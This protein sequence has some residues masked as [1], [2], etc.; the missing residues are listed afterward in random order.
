METE[1][2]PGIMTARR[3]I[4][5]RVWPLLFYQ[6]AC[7]F[8]VGAEYIN[9]IT[10]S[11]MIWPDEPANLVA[12]GGLITGRLW[13]DGI[14]A[15]IWGWLIDR[16]QRKKIITFGSIC[17][18]IFITI[19]V[20][21]PIGGGTPD[22]WFWLI[23]RICIGFFMSQGG[24]AIYSLA[25]DF[26]EK[27]EKSRFFGILM[28]TFMIFQ[29][30]GML[31]GAY[32]F[33]TGA[34]QVFLLISA[35]SYF[36]TAIMATKFI[37]EPKRGI[38]EPALSSILS[39]SEARYE[40]TLNRQTLKSTTFS[41]SNIL[42]LAEGVSTNL[43]FGILDLI[44][45]PFM[46]TE[47]H[48]IAP[49]TTALFQILFSIPGSFIGFIFL[50]K[51]SDRIGKKSLRNRVKLVLCAISTSIITF[52]IVFSLP[53]PALT[54][55]EGANIA[56]MVQYPIFF[57]FGSMFFAN[58]AIIGLYA[59]NQGPII[60]ELNLPESQGT[61]K[62]WNQFIEV[63]S[64]GSGPLVGGF[65]LQF[66]GQNYQATIQL[67]VLFAIPG[68]LLWVIVYFIIERDHKHVQ[69]IISLRALE[70]KKKFQVKD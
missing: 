60:Q 54:K 14:M 18:G 9:L 42:V 70:I 36:V 32:L 13:V 56:I 47:P 49:S 55:E 59:L 58:S 3:S 21:A 67:V 5:A 43:I 44:L 29:Y 23:N 51:L 62:G 17:V 63:A 35:S 45:L 65:L 7:G 37:Q 27:E 52:L 68:I 24:P 31:L 1:P 6:A 2:R 8:F 19:N 33:E 48:N 41:P 46:Q 61:I 30:L 4:F 66:V 34:W 40:Y 15:I 12:M 16:F 57:F 39:T 28:I 38:R 11:H 53:W 20:F 22:Y 10:L 50:A 69:D 64:Y 25:N 26:L